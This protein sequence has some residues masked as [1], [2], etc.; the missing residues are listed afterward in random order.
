MDQGRQRRSHWGID[1]RFRCIYKGYYVHH[2]IGRGGVDILNRKGK[3]ENYSAVHSAPQ[4]V[5]QWGR[6]SIGIFTRTTRWSAKY[7]C[8]SLETLRIYYLLCFTY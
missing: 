7:E 5:I 4:I 3:R 1:C 2:F 6:Y 8:D